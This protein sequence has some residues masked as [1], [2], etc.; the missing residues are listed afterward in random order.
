MF[1]ILIQTSLIPVLLS[2]LFFVKKLLLPGTLRIGPFSHVGTLFVDCGAD[3]IFMDSTCRELKC[4]FT[5]QSLPRLVAGILLVERHNPRINWVSRMVDFDSPYCLENYSI[6]SDSTPSWML[7]RTPTRP[8][9]DDIFKEFTSV[10][11]KKQFRKLPIHRD[12]TATIDLV[13]TLLPITVR[14]INLPGE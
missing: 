5:S 7:L 4:R 10:F 13:P 2:L 14:F 12:S 9:P 11:S 6:H 3:D 1:Q 8:V